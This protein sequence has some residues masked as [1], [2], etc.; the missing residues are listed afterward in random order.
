LRLS[1]QYCEIRESSPKPDSKNEDSDEEG[2]PKGVASTVFE[3]FVLLMF[4]RAEIIGFSCFF[5]LVRTSIKFWVRN[6]DV[7]KVIC[8][9]IKYLPVFSHGKARNFSQAI[10]S[11][12]YDDEKLSMYSKRLVKEEGSD[13]VRFRWYGDLTEDSLVFI[14]RKVKDSR[15]EMAIILST[16]NSL[17]YWV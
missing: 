11:I 5:V 16:S 2:K 14:E 1:D 4:L 9:I 13:L 15:N 10:T 6:A 3:R 12:Y 17:K 7:T 8:R